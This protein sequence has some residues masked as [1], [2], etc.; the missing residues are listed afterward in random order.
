[1]RGKKLTNKNKNVS[2]PLAICGQGT[3]IMLE[4]LTERGGVGF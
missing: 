4:G 1:M 3:D 2:I